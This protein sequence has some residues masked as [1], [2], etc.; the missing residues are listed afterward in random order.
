MCAV[1]IVFSGVLCTNVAVS[2][3]RILFSV[4]LL[5]LGPEDLPGS[6]P[7]LQKII[8][9][10]AFSGMLV[11]SSQLDTALALANVALDLVLTLLFSYLVLAA[12][13][14]RARFVQTTA[15]I[16]G[17]GIFFHLF[18]WPL[19]LQQEL[20]DAGGIARTLMALI[21]LS[22]I[23][24]ELLVTAHIF[25]R[26]IESSMTSAIA[27]SFALF[28]LSITVSQIIFPGTS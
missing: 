12:L 16:C 14:R 2:V 17:I 28:M 8:L 27:L 18:T 6:I 15:A 4:I 9:I 19:L 26:A 21:M 24:W 10:N 1:V 22:L 3:L 5:K 23:S 25:R 20:S 7:V 13:N 11:L